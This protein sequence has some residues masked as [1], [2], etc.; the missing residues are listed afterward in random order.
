MSGTWA[1]LN[2][3]TDFM[4]LE[5]LLSEEAR[6]VRR[7]AREFVNR[8]VLPIIEQHAQAQTFPR[9]LAGRRST[10]SARR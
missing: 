6:M 8:E 2:H 1:Q 4:G 5:G 3:M 7:A 9:H 10:A